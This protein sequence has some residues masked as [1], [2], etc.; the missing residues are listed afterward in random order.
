MMGFPGLTASVS[1]EDF[2]MQRVNSPPRAPDQTPLLKDWKREMQTSQSE[3]ET[4]FPT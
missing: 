2:G 4:V 3:T 1:C